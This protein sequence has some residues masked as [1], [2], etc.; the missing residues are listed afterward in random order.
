[1][2]HKKVAILQRVCPNYRV[3]LFGKLTRY[4]G[5]RLFIGENIP[6][7]K[8]RSSGNLS[9][10]EYVKLDTA[11]IRVF[12]RVFVYH[13]KL[14]K[15]LRLFRPDTIICEGDSHIL[16][17][18]LAIIYKYFFNR[19]VKLVYWCYI[20]IPG[21]EKKS[22]LVRLHKRFSRSFFSSFITYSSYGERQLLLEKKEKSSIF[23]ATNVAC[24]DEL[25]KVKL[26][27]KDAKKKYWSDRGYKSDMTIVYSGTLDI[28]KRPEVMVQIARELG[29]KNI[30]V[31]ILGDGVMYEKLHQIIHKEKL[32]NIYMPGKLDNKDYMECLSHSDLLI[33]PGRG[34]VVIS[35]AMALGMPAIVHQADGIEIDLI[36]NS[37]IGSIVETSDLHSFV[38]AIIF[39]Y[40]NPDVLKDHARRARLLI[41]DEYNTDAMKEKILEA[42]AYSCPEQEADAR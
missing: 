8:V 13:K 7:S 14:L 20:S 41:K 23:A 21:E 30:L 3:N 40:N 11:F 5:I 38:D 35:E 42:V 25:L 27:N 18:L 36:L 6:K 28:N 24:T 22:W 34:G 10:V 32:A 29:S 31:V 33:V 9:G 16:G 17:Y 15:S 4:P 1:M 12:G 26:K 39:Y 37:G 19:K 2:K